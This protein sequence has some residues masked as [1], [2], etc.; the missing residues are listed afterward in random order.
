MLSSAPLLESRR[1][2]PASLSLGALGV[3]Q[4][5]LA[6]A[7]GVPSTSLSRMLRGGQPLP[8]GLKLA[9]RA[10]IGAYGT[11]WVL[12]AIAAEAGR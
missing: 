6:D 8:A 5:K 3:S 2:S 10:S 7:L 12:A 1:R 11:D 9:L 4:A